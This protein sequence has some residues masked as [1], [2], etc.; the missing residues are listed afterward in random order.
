MRMV[1]VLVVFANHLWGWPRGGFVG[2]DVFF[3]ISGFLITGNLLRTA[4]TQGNID[5]GRFYLN[6]IRRIV[7]AASVVLLFTYLAYIVLFLPFRAH[8]VGIDALYAFGFIANWHFLLQG[9][10]YFNASADSVSPIQHY[11][12]LSIEEQF[13]FVWPAIIFI[14]G[15]V[16]AHNTIRRNSRSMI[17]GAT[18][19]TIVVASFGWAVY[20]SFTAPTWAYFNTFSRVWE[21]GVGAILATATGVL[22]QLPTSLRPFLS[23]AGLGLIFTALFTISD[24]SAGFP[25]PWALLPVLGAA[26]VIG[27]GVGTEPRYQIFLRNPISTYIG[28]ISY[29]L[30]LTHWP[31]IVI[32]SAILEP[33][34]ALQ[35]MILTLSFGLSIASY[36][37]VENPM[38]RAGL[39]EMR[40]VL[41]EVRRRR[42]RARQSSQIA[43]MGALAL[44]SVCGITYVSRPGIFEQAT[45]LPMVS[46]ANE[47]NS[48]PATGTEAGPLTASLHI[49]IVKALKSTEWPALTPSMESVITGP[50]VAED[51]LECGSIA[52]PD[53][54]KCT[55]GAKSAK[56]KIVLVGNSIGM[57]YS[58]PLREIAL[59]SDSALSVHTEAMAGCNFVEEDITNSDQSLVDACPVRKQHAIDVINTIKPDIVIISNSYGAKR[60]VGAND[61]LTNVEW[62]KS[63]RRIVD[64]FM[65]N[66]KKVVFL[67]PP[68]GDVDISNCYGKRA[69]KPPSCIGQVDGVWTSMAMAEKDLA[70]SLNGVWI[71]SRPWFCS[72]GRICPSFVGNTPTKRDEAH[73]SPAYGERIYPVI[74]EAL[75]AAGLF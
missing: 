38:R 53:P 23:W 15:I 57:T 39:D 20:E 71:D 37:F 73:M 68:P 35:I 25:A 21:L 69:N 74:G 32:L 30:Y 22:A 62:V 47:D 33:G 72:G 44:V 24:Q 17:A 7:P 2:V 64:K 12:S 59:H 27:S 61:D 52:F 58:G 75:K 54:A 16:V 13:Y 4:E 56:T 3:V 65:M 28:D 34:V 50:Q 49:E 63:M 26:L 40:R 10:D 66:T 51:L 60:V 18:M 36:H 41:H 5:F 11:W 70:K 14:I 9:T 1:A 42:Y 43:A 48:K 6:R 29:S 46:V 45:P 8:E 55:W 67:S 19:V 31:I